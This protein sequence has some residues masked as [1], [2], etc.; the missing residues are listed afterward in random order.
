[1]PNARRKSGTSNMSEIK[2][3]STPLNINKNTSFS[4]FKIPTFETKVFDVEF[5]SDSSN[6]EIQSPVNGNEKI[7]TINTGLLD[8]EP[9]IVLV[10][11]FK[12]LYDSEKRTG[13]GNALNVKENSKIINAKTSLELLTQSE[14]VKKSASDN[15]KELLDYINAESDFT[16]QLIKNVNKCLDLLDLSTYAIPSYKSSENIGSLYEILKKSGYQSSMIT[17]FSQTKLWQQS[18]V[19]LKKSLLSHSPEILSER[20]VRGESMKDWDPFLLS[21]IDGYPKNQKRLW[22]TTYFKVPELKSIIEENI[23]DENARIVE[24]FSNRQ[25]VNLNTANKDTVEQ[26]V[27][28]KTIDFYAES[29]RDISIISNIIFKESYISRYINSADGSSLL[30]MT[31]GYNGSK[32]N[33]FKVWDHVVGRFSDNVKTPIVNPT[34]AGNSLT[35]FSQQ[36]VGAGLD[37]FN[38]LTFEKNFLE[39][40][41]ST[42]GTYYYVDSCLNTTNGVDFDTSRLDN[43]INLSRNG[44]STIS[45]IY[46]M[47][48]YDLSKSQQKSGI[49]S[50]IYKKKP[51]DYVY[52]FEGLSE[53]LSI[54]SN[55]YAKCLDIDPKFGYLNGL[56]YSRMKGDNS[57]VINS[58]ESV[59]TRLASMIC[60]AAVYPTGGYKDI[61]GKLKSY[62]FLWVMNLLDR[63]I[64]DPDKVQWQGDMQ[65]SYTSYKNENTLNL[66]KQKI[67]SLL[68]SVKSTL[69][70]GDVEEARSNSRSY[71]LS[72]VNTSEDPSE[73]SYLLSNYQSN[74]ESKIFDMSGMQGVWGLIVSVLKKVYED[75]SLYAEEKT[76][77]SGIS[78]TAYMFC[79]FDLMLRIIARQTPENLLG[80]YSYAFSYKYDSKKITISESGLIV[81]NCDISTLNEIYGYNGLGILRGD[82]ILKTNKNLESSYNFLKNEED[83]V[84]KQLMVYRR[85]FFDLGSSLNSLKDFLL[86]NYS[87]Q[88]Q[89]M[90]L[91]YDSDTSLTEDQKSALLNLSFSE[92]QIR[93]SRYVMSEMKDRISVTNDSTAKIKSIPQLSTIPSGSLDLLPVNDS[94]LT[95]FSSLSPYFNSLEFLKIKGSNKKIIS[96]G[97]PPKLI[98]GLRT[99]ARQ[100]RDRSTDLKNGII[101]IN[102]F[103]IDR[104]H[105]AVVYLP[106]TYLFEMNRYPTR[107]LSNWWNLEDFRTD[108]FNILKIPSKTVTIDGQVTISRDYTGSFPE[109]DYGNYLTE[110]QK[111]EIYSNHSISFLCEEYLRWFTDCRFDET[112]YHNFSQLTD[113][114]KNVDEQ[115]QKYVS[116]VGRRQNQGATLSDT[117]YSVTTTFTDPT[118]GT[119]FEIPVEKTSVS[120]QSALSQSETS[121][122][123]VIPMNETLKTYFNNE[124]FLS[125]TNIFKRRITYPKKF[126]RVFSVLVDPDDFYVDESITPEQVLQDLKTAGVL[127]GGHS[128]KKNPYKNRDMGPDDVTLDEYFVTV[129]PFDYQ[130]EYE[131]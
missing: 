105:P 5:F 84:A 49:Y 20:N 21:D 1:M 73:N 113:T 22:V 54:V 45:S 120:R 125:D 34:G 127:T 74:I 114:L 99:S 41:N 97:I 40:S 100:S 42:P 36:S 72:I 103:K 131:A 57:G 25:Y 14:D 11:E 39:N 94:E 83:T 71:V 51:L 30:S 98:R 90:K 79:Y 55:L 53:K 117:S 86:K 24:K 6:A 69:S 17:R 128:N 88:L 10:S 91:L 126:D 19:E 38:V 52:T 129:E 107:I 23:I 104:L 46:N 82:S 62:L 77:Y 80:S 56:K 112:R 28:A 58:F 78:K 122:K 48:G 63:Q 75:D 37:F 8:T 119:T 110:N 95:S 67:S 76:L 44:H 85:Y 35:S 108:G 89:K 27:L 93:L 4:K 70:A 12:P 60:K 87:K 96:V 106:K 13:E 59:Y 9:A 118:S 123:F 15:K 68:G 109:S 115:F 92:E 102:V 16:L 50:E 18:L 121:K 32:D 65:V 66:I 64:S 7:F 116:L 31:F 111:L 26:T 2:L 130:Q 43:L 81:K 47:I 3:H 29:K 61:S 101:R 124:T 33:N